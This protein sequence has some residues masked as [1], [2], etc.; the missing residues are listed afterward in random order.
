MESN[1]GSGR[2]ASCA[3]GA[4]PGGLS[5]E[6]NPAGLAVGGFRLAASRLEARRPGVSGKTLSLQPRRSVRV[7]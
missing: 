2:Q 1:G 3:A 5:W 6:T 7:P 4:R